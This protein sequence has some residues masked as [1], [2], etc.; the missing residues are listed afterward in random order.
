[1]SEKEVFAFENDGQSR[2]TITLSL[3]ELENVKEITYSILE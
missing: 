1:M 2:C 3:E